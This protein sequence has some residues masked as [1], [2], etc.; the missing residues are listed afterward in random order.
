MRRRHSTTL[1][2]LFLAALVALPGFGPQPAYAHSHPASDKAHHS[3]SDRDPGRHDHHDELPGW[4]D[5]FSHVHGSWFGIPVT[6]PTPEGG[7]RSASMLAWVP[8]PTLTNALKAGPFGP[9][10]ERI[11][12]GSG[13]SPPD[14]R[15][16][17]LAA[18]P[19]RAPLDDG[20]GTAYVLHGRTVVLRC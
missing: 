5:S 12:W 4:S 11:P 17:I 18:R 9:M 16:F 7:A 1:L 8:C 20:A 19:A 10:K 3:H 2:R 6:V 15:H 13:L 14:L